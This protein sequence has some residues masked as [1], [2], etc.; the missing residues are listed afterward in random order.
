MKFWKK[1]KKNKKG[2]GRRWVTFFNFKENQEESLRSFKPPLQEHYQVAAD[3][4]NHGNQ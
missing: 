3:N 1:S 4:S 2:R